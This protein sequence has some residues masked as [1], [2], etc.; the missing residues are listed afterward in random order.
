M[1]SVISW[2]S[3][4]THATIDYARKLAGDASF[5]QYFELIIVS[6]SRHFLAGDYDTATFSLRKKIAAA[7]SPCVAHICF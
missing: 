2:G 1:K 6:Y 4:K 7:Q 3:R 5:P